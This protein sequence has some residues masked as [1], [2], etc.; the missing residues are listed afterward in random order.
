[1]SLLRKQTNKQ[2]AIYN[3]Y[4]SQLCFGIKKGNGDKN[5]PILVKNTDYM[6]LI[7]GEVHLFLLFPSGKK[8]LY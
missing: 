6:Y 8:V 7:L 1:M 4:V 5:F 3:V 2:K